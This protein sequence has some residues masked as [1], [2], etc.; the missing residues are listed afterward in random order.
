[1]SLEIRKLVVH[2]EEVATEGGRSDDG[3]PLRKVAALA[4]IR[5][6]YAGREWSASLDGLIE[7]SGEL[8]TLLA[9]RASE[10]LGAPVESYGKGAIV[11][12]GGEQE[13]AVACLTSVFGDAY[14]EAIGGGKAWIPSVTKRAA[15]GTS[16]DI[17]VAFHDA[18]WVR[19]HYDAVTVRVQDAPLP[20]E[21]LVG[22]AMTNRGRINARVGGLG[23]DEVKGEDGLR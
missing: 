11:G 7:P 6:P 5:N 21:I 10:V 4:V 9:K 15:V 2:E 3:G 12:L 20:D 19:S 23:K 22:L 18:L 14:R 17:P 16:L 8:A 1:M 13:H